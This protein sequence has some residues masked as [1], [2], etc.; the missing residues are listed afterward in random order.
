MRTSLR[1]VINAPLSPA[2]R[3]TSEQ[4]LVA[5]HMGLSENIFAAIWADGWA[6][7]LDRAIECALELAQLAASDSQATSDYRVD[8][9]RMSS[10][11]PREYDVAALIARGLTNRQ[12]ASELIIAERTVDTHVHNILGKLSLTSRTQVAAWG[13]RQGLVPQLEF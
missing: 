5:G 6:L 10:L 8:A 9:D 13:V 4:A 3:L 7:P 1:E 2:E 11:T 12:I